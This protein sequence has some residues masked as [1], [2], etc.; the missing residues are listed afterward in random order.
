[1][2]ICRARKHTRARALTQTV[3][4]NPK[5]HFEIS[6]QEHLQAF[7]SKKLSF[8][9]ANLRK[10]EQFRSCIP[11]VYENTRGVRLSCIICAVEV[12]LKYFT[13]VMKRIVFLWKKSS[14][15]RKVTATM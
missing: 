1:M 5:F 8:C 4:L 6:I 3:E 7:I 11:T 12:F 10:T 14:L 2:I 9:H 13:A 15:P